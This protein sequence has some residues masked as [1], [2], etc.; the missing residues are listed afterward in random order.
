MEH[1]GSPSRALTVL[2]WPASCV[3]VSQTL[4]VFLLHKKISAVE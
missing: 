1:R 4:T 2:L 3:C